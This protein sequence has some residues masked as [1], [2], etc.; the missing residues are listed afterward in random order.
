MARRVGH[1]RAEIIAAANALRVLPF[2]LDADAANAYVERILELARQIGAR[3]FE[4][5]AMVAHAAILALSGRKSEALD[6]TLRGLRQPGRLE[7]NFS[8]RT[9]WVSSRSS[10]KTMRCDADHWRKAKNCCARAR[11]AITTCGSTAM[12]SRR[13]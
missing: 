6:L 8:A 9:S 5:E 7:S 4:S 13:R 11:S 1:Q 2:L 12:R 3:R 10:P